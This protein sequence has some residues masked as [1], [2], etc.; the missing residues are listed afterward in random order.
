L[1]TPKFTKPKAEAFTKND[2]GKPKF[3]L[4]AQ[5]QKELGQINDVMEYGAVKYGR[6]NW[7][8]AN[9]K[10]SIDR[11]LDACIRH[12]LSARNG[13][14]RDSESNLCHLDHALANLL[15]IQHLRNNPKENKNVPQ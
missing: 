11:Y 2:S 8:L 12:V 10:E 9:D 5:F 13:D 15:F 6:D 4:I 1:T 3:S 7:K 14:V